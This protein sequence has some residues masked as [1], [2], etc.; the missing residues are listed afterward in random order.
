MLEYVFKQLA[1]IIGF[2]IAYLM[3]LIA[4]P[5]LIDLFYMA[6]YNLAVLMAKIIT[7]L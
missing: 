2:F 1:T 5:Y 4:E 3:Y 7:R 6:L